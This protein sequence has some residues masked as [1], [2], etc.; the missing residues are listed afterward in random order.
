MTKLMPK[1]LK[2]Y[3]SIYWCC[4]LHLLYYLLTQIISLTQTNKAKMDRLLKITNQ[5]SEGAYFWYLLLEQEQ[6][7]LKETAF[8]A[9]LLLQWCV[10]KQKTFPNQKYRNFLL[11][12]RIDAVIFQTPMHDHP[13]FHCLYIL[14]INIFVIFLLC[15]YNCKTSL[16]INLQHFRFTF[17]YKALIKYVFGNLSW[18]II[19]KD[20]QVLADKLNLKFN[21]RRNYFYE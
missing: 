2:R 3:S 19:R 17:M 11:D 15:F 16:E 6:S 20:G 7:K 4:L 1:Q 12:S 21:V 8:K 14:R 9:D 10:T 18:L 13:S 5:L